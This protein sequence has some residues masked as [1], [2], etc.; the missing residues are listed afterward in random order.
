MKA[1]ILLLILAAAV[2]LPQQKY[3]IFFTDKEISEE[4]L[5]TPDMQVYKEVLHTL[6]ERTI[7]RR[8][9]AMGESIV[10]YEDIPVN[11]KYIQKVSEEGGAVVRVLNW[12]NAVSVYA[13]VEELERIKELPFVK[14]IRPV[15]KLTVTGYNEHMFLTNL[16]SGN[17]PYD[18]PNG[19][20]Y[21]N[22]YIQLAMSNIP[23]VHAYGFTGKGVVIGM[24]DS[25]FDW[26]R[27]EALADANVIA[28]Y[29]FI[30]K[31]SVTANEEPDVRSQDSHGTYCF[32]I[33]GGFSNG[34][35]IGAAFDAGFILAK[36]EDSRSETNVEE[37]NYAAALEWM[38]KNGVDIT[39]SSLGYTTFDD[40]TQ[41]YSYESLDGLT[42]IC[43][44][45]ATLAFER[46][47]ITVT[48]AGN[49]G[50]DI[51]KYISAPADAVNILSVA[52]VDK[53]YDPASFSSF[54]PTYDGRIS[55]LISTLGVSVL[56]ATAGSTGGYNFSNGTSAAAPIAAGIA[57]LL[58]SAHP[59]LNN[60]QVRHSLIQ[61]AYNPDNPD[62]RRGFGLLNAK[63][64]IEYP[65]IEK[66]ED[67]ILLHKMFLS[68]GIDAESVL[69]HFSGDTE[70][71]EI[72][73]KIDSIHY[74]YPLGDFESDTPVDFYFTYTAEGKQYRSPGNENHYYSC[75]TETDTVSYVG[76][77]EPYAFKLHKNYPEPFDLVTRFSF[78]TKDTVSINLTIVDENDSTVFDL[79]TGSI[80][81]GISGFIWDGSTNVRGEKVAPGTY[82]ARLKANDL[83]FEEDITFL[84]KD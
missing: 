13:S 18:A 34:V 1:I 46:G 62:E 83:I 69:I 75:L 37:D 24:L 31:D 21:G 64:A 20:D 65:A 22:S 81:K 8:L 43:S 33:V 25:G 54:G 38:E 59:Y 57:G 17:R 44:K 73:T 9:S 5:I 19:I 72:M 55:P 68:D 84:P 14:E 60:V 47:I 79:Y 3:F 12:L 28:E 6:S 49:E 36:T 39:T 74:S 66:T 35:L 7:M 32:S 11:R 27:H 78:W 71:E 50:N 52:A 67:V 80:K 42:A 2:A 16:I 70:T 58:L 63:D 76:K 45:A 26:E 51:W 82:T 40:S 4:T 29:D 61:T 30:F 53:R 77:R 41:D 56:G 23:E 10:T 15:Q 48:A